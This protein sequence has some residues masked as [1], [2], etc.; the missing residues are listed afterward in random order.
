LPLLEQGT[1]EKHKG[2]VVE[3]LEQHRFILQKH[4]RAWESAEIAYLGANY[5]VHIPA[6][7]TT[8]LKLSLDGKLN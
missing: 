2:G 6:I 1:I 3:S 5:I 8:T 4:E 7:L